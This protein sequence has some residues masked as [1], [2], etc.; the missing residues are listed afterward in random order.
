M[1]TG[2]ASDAVSGTQS[3]TGDAAQT[4]F[5][6]SLVMIAFLAIALF[7]AA[8]LA[9]L[10]LITFKRYSG[11]YFWSVLVAAGGIP[12]YCLGFTLK[13]FVT[14]VPN[15][16]YI[17]LA[18]VI[19]GWVPM[20]TGQS[21][22]LYSRLN[23]VVHDHRKLRWVLWMIIVNGCVF[24]GATTGLAFSAEG[25]TRMANIYSAYE[26]AELTAF[27]VQECIISGL[28]IYETWKILRPTTAA[29]GKRITAVRRNLICV[30]IIVILL[31]VALIG[32]ELANQYKLQTTLKAF[33]YSVKLGLEFSVLNTLLRAIQ[34]HSSSSYDNE[35]TGSANAGFRSGAPGTSHGGV[36][37][38]RGTTKTRVGHSE[39]ATTISNVGK[40]DGRTGAWEMN[41]MHNIMKTTEVYVDSSAGCAADEDAESGSSKDGRRAGSKTSSEIQLTGNNPY[42]PGGGD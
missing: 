24:H 21:L 17:G 1:S 33:V 18:F 32:I 9:V 22:A 30:N 20:V 25:S 8:E 28:Y 13:F 34:G 5:A 41:D 2:P 37:T 39:H 35:N 12:I 7:N 23:L 14:D 40:S 38:F 29:Q 15:M 11:L 42:Y 10:V 16:N 19:V 3:K 31:D 27:A 36:D 26:K 6:M 4:T